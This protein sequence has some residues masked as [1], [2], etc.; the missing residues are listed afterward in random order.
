MRFLIAFF[1][2]CST[3]AFAQSPDPNVERAR[4]HVRAGIAYYD[5]GRYEDA[6]REMNAAYALKPVADLQYNLAQCYE[7]LA[8]YDEAAASY[9]KY[10]DGKPDA[11]DAKEVRARVA[12]LKARTPP[13]PIE[14]VVLK[15]IVVY[16]QAPP[17]PGRAARWAAYGLGVL[18]LGAL[19]SGITFAVLASEAAKD[20]QSGGNVLNP[21]TFDGAVRDKQ[22][23]GKT[24]PIIAGV[25]F[26]LAGL[27]AGGAVALYLIGNKIDRE[28]PK[29]TWAPALLP[30]GGGALVA[31]GRF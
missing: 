13:K 2:L 30:G 11:P 12:N 5:E 1:V 26:G 21:P 15:T 23:S 14:K 16:R 28:A 19:A 17:P 10:L 29:V 4:I 18:A 25:S 9:E 6:A 24:Y 7:R 20:V 22:E 8:R 3:V 27:A 31:M